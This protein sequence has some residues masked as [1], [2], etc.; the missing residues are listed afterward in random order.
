MTGYSNNSVKYFTPNC[1]VL[2]IG[3][4]IQCEKGDGYKLRCLKLF[5]NFQ[6][7]FSPG[8]SRIWSIASLIYWSDIWSTASLS[9]LGKNLHIPISN[10]L[11]N[12]KRT[13]PLIQSCSLY[14]SKNPP[15]DWNRWKIIARTQSSQNHLEKIRMNLEGSCFPIS[16]VTT[17]LS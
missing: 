4:E 17:R 15:Y 9:N 3:Y 7:Q 5:H 2:G 12:L 6:H 1:V 11:R 13:F 14:M 10:A 16:K 8:T